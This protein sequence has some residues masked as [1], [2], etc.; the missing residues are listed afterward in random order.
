[1]VWSLTALLFLAVTATLLLRVVLFPSSIG[2]LLEDPQQPLFLG[3]FPMTLSTL[4]NGVVLLLLPRCD[5]GAPHS[6]L[7]VSA[8]NMLCASTMTFTPQ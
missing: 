7:H 1:V 3:A 8:L 5:K 2:P 6:V 4:N